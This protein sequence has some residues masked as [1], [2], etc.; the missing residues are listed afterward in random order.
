[1]K[2][3]LQ[4]SKRRSP[5]MIHLCGDRRALLVTWPVTVSGRSYAYPTAQLGYH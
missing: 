3:I 1:M 5:E 4:N 2:S